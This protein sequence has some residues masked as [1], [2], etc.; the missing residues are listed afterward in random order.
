MNTGFGYQP[1]VLQVALAPAAV[2]LQ[3][4]K[5]IGWLLLVAANQVSDQP[6]VVTGAAHQRCLH[7]VVRHDAARHAASAADVCQRAML[8]KRVDADDGV[9]TLSCDSPI[10]QNCMPKVK[11]RPVTREANCCA[12]A[13]SV[14]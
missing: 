12:R 6:Y 7:K 13:C 11:R 4:G 14:T 1:G 5:Q 10:C 2:A 9:V 8:H 3:F